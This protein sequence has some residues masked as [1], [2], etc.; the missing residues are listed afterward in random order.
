MNVIMLAEEKTWIEAWEQVGA[1][2]R[3]AK[4]WLSAERVLG[5]VWSQRPP[6]PPGSGRSQ[7]GAD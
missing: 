6:G 4:Q 1:W 7:G 2:D 5:P 3:A